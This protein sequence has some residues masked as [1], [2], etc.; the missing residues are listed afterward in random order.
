MEENETREDDQLVLPNAV[1]CPDCGQ[2]YKTPQGLAGHRRLAHSTNTARVLD[3]RSRGLGERQR[4]LDARASEIER[5]EASARRQVEATR[6]RET[7]L[8]RRERAVRDAE[9][10][11]SAEKVRREIARF[12]QGLPEHGEQEIV[13]FDGTDYRVEDGGLTHVFFPDGAKH[14]HEEGDLFRIGETVYW[15][16]N[17]EAVRLSHGQIAETILEWEAEATTDASEEG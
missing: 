10:T 1:A 13:R 14:E 5:K 6:R 8:T 15:V 12:K 4:A 7:A 16:R 17:G 3:E 2:S 11:T 9:A